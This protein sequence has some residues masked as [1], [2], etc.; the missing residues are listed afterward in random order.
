MEDRSQET[1]KKHQILDAT[2][3][4]LSSRGL[5]ALSFEAVAGEAGLSRQLVRY[6]FADLDELVGALCDHLAG[7]YREMLLSGIVE[8][9]KAG[10]V[11]RLD[12]FLD[13][14]FDLAAGHPMP[15]N[16]ETYD[17][18]IAY[19]VGSEALRDRMCN[20]YRTL[21]HVIM[22]ELAIAYPQL[23]SAACEE[24][25]FLFVSMMHAHWSFVASLG[26]SR[27]HS[28]L[29]RR[30]FDRIVRSYIEEAPGAP[31]MEEPWARAR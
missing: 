18:M 15:V 26:Y 30:A 11:E 1:N 28:R 29:A 21:G 6:Y 14:F 8:A 27:A 10:K 4:L 20:Q 24:L 12:F 7:M 22:H 31:L 5:Q 25:S 17:A 9:D 2:A 16:L 23:G 19:A 13:F 3:R